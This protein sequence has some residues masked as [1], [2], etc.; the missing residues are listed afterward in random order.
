MFNGFGD[1]MEV[2]LV[3]PLSNEVWRNEVLK[4]LVQRWYKLWSSESGNWQAFGG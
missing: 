4:V 2:R 1:V 3:Q